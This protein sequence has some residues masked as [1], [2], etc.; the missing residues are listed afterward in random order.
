MFSVDLSINVL[1][2][3]QWFKRFF[4]RIRTNVD[5]KGT[6][7]L[8]VAVFFLSHFHVRLFILLSSH[9][10]FMHL[11]KLSLFNFFSLT[12]SLSFF[13]SLSLSFVL[14]SYFFSLSFPLS[15]S[16]FCVAFFTFDFLFHVLWLSLLSFLSVSISFCLCHSLPLSLSVSLS[17]HFR[18]SWQSTFNILFLSFILFSCCS[19]QTSFT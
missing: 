13:L 15:F 11:K 2:P 14:A 5:Q 10:Q 12:L 17:F 18:R 9:L 19:S 6:L 4:A 16:S 3:P 8:F 7:S 1:C